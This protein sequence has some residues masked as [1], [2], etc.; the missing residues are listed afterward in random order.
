MAAVLDEGLG[1]RNA[2]LLAASGRGGMAFRYSS[3][4]W[5][6]RSHCRWLTWQASISAFSSS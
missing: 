1:G 6:S 4:P 2:D 3:M 5:W